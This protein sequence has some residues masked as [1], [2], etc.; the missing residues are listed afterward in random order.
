[1]ARWL[2]AQ[3]QGDDL[4]SRARRSSARAVAPAATPTASKVH[5]PQAE[6]SL[7]PAGSTRGAAAPS[8]RTTH[9][10]ANRCCCRS[11][12]SPPAT[13]RSCR[14]IRA[15]SPTAKSSPDRLHSLAR[16]PRGRHAMTRRHAR[17][18]TSASAA[19][20]AISAPATPS[21]PGSPPPTTSASPSCMRPRS[22]SSSSSAASR[23]RW[24]GS[25][26]SRLQAIS[27][28]R[29]L[30][31]A[32]HVPWRRDGVV[33][34]GAVD[35]GH[36]RQFS[37]AADDRRA[38]MSRFRASICSAGISSSPAASARSTR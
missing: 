22:P 27:F 33:L 23:S 1:M 21:R 26:C 19:T 9:I 20:R 3:P 24:S 32:V 7:R 10:C 34:P 11:G 30:Q 31:Q 38:V 25:S 2:A 17:R 16:R 35:P 37:A 13:S 12:T 5:A 15:F 4:A 14:A 8:S 29:H 18:R 36:L 28:G 6:R